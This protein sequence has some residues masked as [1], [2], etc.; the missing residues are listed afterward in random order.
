MDKPSA[1]ISY[2][3]RM[4]DE[5]AGLLDMFERQGL[6][7][8]NRSIHPWNPPALTPE[9]VASLDMRIRVATH[10]IVL[11]GDDLADSPCCR[12]EIEI[13]RRYGK[14]II[15]VYPTGTFGS[16]I[17]EVLDGG[18]YRAIGWR[19]NALERAIRGEYPP[20]G[21]VFDISEDVARRKG[22]ALIGS[23][24]VGTAILFAVQSEH[25]VAVL[26]GELLAAGLAVPE[27]VQ[28][29]IAPWVLGGALS[30]LLVAALLGGRH[31]DLLV[32]AGIGA[33][34]GVGA[35]KMTHTQAELQRLEPLL[36]VR[37][38]LV[39]GHIL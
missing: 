33:A 16:P 5:Y 32:G 23:L 28:A 3:F 14:Q 12:L 7:V 27:P 2:R 17:P 21:R 4:A 34:M 25:E 6:A 11:V 15:A 37:R 38:R 31:G 36:E 8:V 29:N 18:I 24:A 26:R 10:I 22:V 39:H 19:G 9:L 35:G 1:F 30:G 13:A 20:E